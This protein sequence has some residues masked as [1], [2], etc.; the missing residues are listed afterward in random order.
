MANKAPQ[1]ATMGRSR[2]QSAMRASSSGGNAKRGRN[3]NK[4]P[5]SGKASSRARKKKKGGMSVLGKIAIVLCILLLLV[6][7]AAIA[8]V[9][10]KIDKMDF[11]NLDPDKLSINE[12]YEY[13]ETGYLNVALFGLDKRENVEEMGT[14][15]DTIIIASL[16]RET[17][18]VKMSSVYRDTLLQMDDGTYN[19]ANAAYAFG[20]EEEAVAMLNRNLDMDITHY[21]T[22]DFSAM[23]DMIDAVDGIDVEV[24][25][26]EIP[27]LNNYACEIIENTGV[28]TWGI[29]EPGYQH[30]TGVQAT[31]YARIRATEGDDYRRTERQRLVLT[32]IAEKA[33]A[34]S[35]SS[36]NMMIDRVLP[37]VRTNFTLPEILAYAKDVKKY[38]I[39]ETLGF[40]FDLGTMYYGEAGDSVVPNNLEDNVKQLHEFLF[41]EDGY[42]PSSTVSEISD[43]LVFVTGIG[44]PSESNY[45]NHSSGYG[46][47]DYSTSDGA[48]NNSDGYGSGDGTSGGD[49]GY[50]TGDDGTGSYG[51][52][53]GTGT[54][55]SGDW[56]S[57]DGYG[58]GDGTTSGDGSDYGTGS[59]GDGNGYGTSGGDDGTGNQWY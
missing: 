54:D 18:E 3:G 37:K 8:V 39:G 33:Q 9:Y 12:G 55:G 21:V 44:Y 30:L 45:T 47:Q 17:K 5:S 41:G 40:P 25:E 38:T 14:R 10:S 53:Y 36:L 27:Y 13:D 32:K 11:K 50:G 4:R 28:D 22:V 43:E 29:T 57:G 16:N 20:E 58:N 46:S 26:E 52:G 19:K 34:V 23:V 35:L 56:S 49:Y 51:D 1:A 24:T 59:Y 15:S 7:F 2:R 31:A 42:S 48:Y 6:V